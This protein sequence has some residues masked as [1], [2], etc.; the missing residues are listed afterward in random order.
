MNGSMALNIKILFTN[1]NAKG[2]MSARHASFEARV[3]LKQN[4]TRLAVEVKS[5]TLNVT[6]DNIDIKV[7]G[8]GIDNILNAIANFLKTFFFNNIMKTMSETLPVI[9]SDS[10]NEILGDLPDDIEVVPGLSIKFAFTN[11]P[12]IKSGYMITPLLVYVHQ[13]SNPNPPVE[14]PPDLPDFDPNCKKGLQVFFSDYI[15]RSALTTAHDAGMLKFAKVVKAMGFEI[16]L[17]C[18]SVEAPTLEFNGS[19]AFGAHMN[20]MAEFTMKTPKIHF[21]L[22]FIPG[23]SAI[24]EENIEKSMIHFS[25]KKLAF[26]DLK[27]IYGKEID[28]KTL[29]NLL[30]LLVEDFRKH[31]NQEIEKKGIP[32]PIFKKFDL[33]DIE[34]SLVGHHI[35]MCGT[36]RPKEVRLH[37]D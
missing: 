23:V 37:K 28:L 11:A 9:I 30:N 18:T 16:D 26:T 21:K 33:S 34:Q 22:G 4:L 8:E 1:H 6:K 31:I 17:N 27:I 10:I 3:A 35:F 19:I 7:V 13:Q 25:L 20:C 12:A 32:L 14:P 36:I 5:V 29:L 15:I 24:L 2:Y